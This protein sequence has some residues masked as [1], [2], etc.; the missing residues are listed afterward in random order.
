M[1]LGRFQSLLKRINP[2]LRVRQRGYG[3]VGG[4]FVG[5]GGK[6]GYIARIT[7]GD[8]TMK[9]YREAIVDPHNRMRLIEGRIK[10]RGRVTLVNIL[11]NYRWA[12]THQQ[13]S[14]L[15]FGIERKT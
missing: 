12:K 14:M 15:L 6:S 7:K 5:L 4:L 2:K 3:D 10:K 1:T 8:L 13:R 9:G 11:R